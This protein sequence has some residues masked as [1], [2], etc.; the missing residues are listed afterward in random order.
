[1]TAP[2]PTH[3]VAL[4]LYPGAD[5][6]DFT[7]PAEILS[8]A[9]YT[10]R[11]DPVVPVF[12]VI[13][14]AA[15]A[16]TPTPS[17]NR[18]TLHTQARLSI[19]AAR[20]RLAD[21]SVLVVPGANTDV[22]LRMI[23]APGGAP[24]V[25][26]HGVGTAEAFL[27][28]AHLFAH[29]SALLC[30]CG[31]LPHA[32]HHGVARLRA[33]HEV[34]EYRG[35]KLKRERNNGAP[36]REARCGLGE[37]C[38]GVRWV[39]E[40]EEDA[41][42]RVQGKVDGKDALLQLRELRHRQIPVA[43]LG[44][45]L[46]LQSSHVITQEPRPL[47]SG[48]MNLAKVDVGD[49]CC[50][51]QP[52]GGEGDTCGVYLVLGV[53]A[54]RLA[55]GQD[56]DKDCGVLTSVAQLISS[57]SSR[58]HFSVFFFLVFFSSSNRR[59]PRAGTTHTSA[60]T[61][62]PCSEKPARPASPA[63]GTAPAFSTASVTTLVFSTVITLVGEDMTTS[64][65]QPRVD[66]ADDKGNGVEERHPR[67][68]RQEL[69]RKSQRQG[70]CDPADLHDRHEAGSHRRADLVEGAR[71]GDDCHEDQIGLQVS[72][73]ALALCDGFAKAVAE[74]LVVVSAGPT[75]W[76]RA[77][78][79]RGGALRELT[80]GQSSLQGVGHGLLELDLRHGDNGGCL[81]GRS[82]R[83]SVKGFARYRDG[84]DL[85]GERGELGG[86]VGAAGGIG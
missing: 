1:M 49:D 46:T 12:E 52:A 59:K 5:M 43:K 61:S 66:G 41:E 19:A 75:L 45:D 13:A 55:G 67:L 6:L 23:A 39:G 33:I 78:G 84:G 76:Q 72:A 62:R 50:S 4:L 26:G 86:L 47:P 54:Q 10:R 15:D 80:V 82:S 28:T 25:D 14:V 63:S 51:G 40:Q 31:G 71:A 42:T 27:Q 79:K 73:R 17:G 64:Q 68:L 48:S 36:D 29:L 8:S 83:W 38:D 3:K 18:A 69:L 35:D 11:P 16:S 81:G 57:Y 7:G 70:R 20:A 65:V 56:G 9:S 74:A 22:L 37:C 24:E 44:H 34:V 53:E 2:K 32:L 21:F 77:L 30:V 58:M 60:A 85:D